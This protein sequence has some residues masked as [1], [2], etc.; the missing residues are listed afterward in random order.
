M[1]LMTRIGVRELRQNA[2]IYLARVQNG[3]VIEVTVR[4][5][6]VAR[7]VPVVEPAWDRLMA[8]GHIRPPADHARLEDLEPVLVE[9][10]E[11]ASE[12]LRRMREHER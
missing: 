3:E 9:G 8:E 10:P 2:S 12:V 5:K 11:P 7:I 1:C 4:G 6:S